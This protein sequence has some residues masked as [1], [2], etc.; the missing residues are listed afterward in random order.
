SRTT[1]L[2]VAQTVILMLLGVTLLATLA[3]AARLIG[4]PLA[5]LTSVTR[6]IARGD[7]S[8]RAPASG[9]A[10]LRHLAENFDAMTDAVQNDLAA[11]R[12][13]ERA[14]ESADRAKSA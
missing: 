14:A 10:E 13:A 3:L 9:V 2:L 6:R 12:R 8:E 4:S 1:T 7:W 5:R 11:R